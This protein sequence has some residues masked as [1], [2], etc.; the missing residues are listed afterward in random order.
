M[1]SRAIARARVTT[2][3]RTNARHAAQRPRAARVVLVRR[4]NAPT[5]GRRGADRNGCLNDRM[6]NPCA[7]P[8]LRPHSLDAPCCL[9]PRAL[10][11]D[12]LPRGPRQKNGG[13]HL[14]PTS[15]A[16]DAADGAAA[17]ASSTRASA[18]ARARAENT[19]LRLSD[20]R[21]NAHLVPW[22]TKNRQPVER[23]PAG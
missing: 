14:S 17:R 12:D 7:L 3:A 13:A 11:G 1:L 16:R 22:A 23:A 6:R 5:S 19:I 21:A 20:T 15:N 9:S 18:C 8:A 10:C 4:R 2:L